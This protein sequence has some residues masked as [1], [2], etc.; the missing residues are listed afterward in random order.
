MI[1]SNLNRSW[2][3][4]VG[5]YWQ[6]LSRGLKILPYV[7]FTVHILQVMQ[8][9]IYFSFKH[10]LVLLQ[11]RIL[12]ITHWINLALN[13]GYFLWP[14]DATLF[15]SIWP[16]QGQKRSRPVGQR[17]QQCLA[18]TITSVVCSEEYH[19]WSNSDCVW[20]WRLSPF[21]HGGDWRWNVWRCHKFQNSQGS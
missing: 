8:Q 9:L 16:Y 10:K 14:K 18:V 21:R 11:Q 5:S 6:L 19:C 2:I 17:N 1:A 4:Y 12:G 15:L 7:N 3:F 13:Y 20:P